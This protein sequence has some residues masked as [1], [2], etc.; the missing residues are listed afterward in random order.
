MVRR[1]GQ[2]ASRLNAVGSGASGPKRI[3]FLGMGVRLLAVYAG[4]LASTL[5]LSLPARPFAGALGQC[6][7]GLG[8]FDHFPP[9]I[10]IAHLIGDDASF[11]RLSE[12]VVRV[13]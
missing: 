10:R 11:V 5:I 2:S 12:P 3:R 8:N 7:I 6:F 1:F 13:I 4:R 9:R